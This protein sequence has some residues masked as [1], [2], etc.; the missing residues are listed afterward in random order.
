MEL[1][2]ISFTPGGGELG[3]RLEGLLRKD[4][5]SARHTNP[6]EARMAAAGEGALGEAAEKRPPLTLDDW[7]RRGFG[8]EGPEG[9]ARGLIFIGAAGIA[10]RGR[11][12]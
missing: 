1:E 11:C 12:V 5:L 4:G 9:P 2:I 3:R 7:V 6:R 8:L 10:V